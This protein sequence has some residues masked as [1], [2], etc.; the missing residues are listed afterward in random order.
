MTRRPSDIIRRGATITG[1]Q[2]L[3]A[4]ESTAVVP[5]GGRQILVTGS[6]P[7][8]T[9]R[10]AGHQIIPKGGKKQYALLVDSFQFAANRWDYG[11][12]E[13]AIGAGNVWTVKA[14]GLSSTQAG[15][16]KAR[17]FAEVNNTTLKAL[18]GVA[19]SSLTATITVKP[20]A[21]PP[22]QPVEITTQD[23]PGGGL[24]CWF[25]A[26]NP[27]EVTCLSQVPPD[28]GPLLVSATEPAGVVKV[29]P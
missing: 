20:I 5:F 9:I 26:L 16:L 14:G 7:Q 3:N 2:L 19:L 18:Y 27:L 10:Q 29:F 13:A 11:W 17:N 25:E 6:G 21:T 28:P 1:R 8:A 12:K 24:A 4:I 23:V 15:V 22:S